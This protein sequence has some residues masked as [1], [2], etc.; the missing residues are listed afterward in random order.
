M[1]ECS[2][3]AVIEDNETNQRDIVSFRHWSFCEDEKARI[4]VQKLIKWAKVIAVS[5]QVTKF[6]KLDLNKLT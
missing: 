4:A 1:S 2:W 6:D 3:V 5:R